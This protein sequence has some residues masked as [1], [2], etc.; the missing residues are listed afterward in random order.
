MLHIL[1]SV[2][3]RFVCHFVMLLWFYISRQFCVFI[4]ALNALLFHLEICYK[5]K[6]FLALK[7]LFPFGTRHLTPVQTLFEVFKNKGIAVTNISQHIYQ[8]TS[9]SQKLICMHH[10]RDMS[11]KSSLIPQGSHLKRK[12]NYLQNY[13]QYL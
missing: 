8:F 1:F 13:I 9:C 11:C 12:N 10:S 2:S 6:P 5:R 4:I 3:I 7:R